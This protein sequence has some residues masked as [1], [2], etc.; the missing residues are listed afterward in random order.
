LVHA[1]DHPAAAAREETV[2][3]GRTIVTGV[4]GDDIHVMGIRLVEHALRAAGA[5]VA[6]LGVMTPVSEFVEA[7]V[8]TAA[9]AVVMSSSNGHAALSCDGIREA[10]IEAGRGDVLLYIGGNL[11]VGR[12]VTHE[13]VE[14]Q[15]K[16]L[17]FDRVFAPNADLEDA[18]AVL[19]GDLR[20]RA[21]QT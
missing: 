6:S 11:K 15:Y 13:E 5:K 16:L 4:P 1:P 9:D 12:G 8:E 20:P 7:A 3:A 2:L 18:I 21:G 14:R 19:A 10:F 17:G